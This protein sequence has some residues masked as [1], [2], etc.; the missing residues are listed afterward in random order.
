MKLKVYL[1]VCENQ[2]YVMSL[3]TVKDFEVGWYLWNGLGQEN[4]VWDFICS[5]VEGLLNSGILKKEYIAKSDLI[6][7]SL[8]SITL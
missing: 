3:L 7:S 6:K 8:K 2:F 5:T 1:G 4:T